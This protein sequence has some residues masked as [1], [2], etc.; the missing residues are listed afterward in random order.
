MFHKLMRLIL[1]V[2]LLLLLWLKATTITLVASTKG[3]A[4]Q[5]IEKERNALLDFRSYIDQ[6][7]YD[8]LFTWAVDEETTR[9]C[10]KWGGVTCNSRTRHVTSFDS[11][12]GDLE[13]KI[14]PSLL[15]LSY[16]SH[17]DLHWNS[18]N[19]TISILNGSMT[20]LRYLDLSTNSLSGDIPMFI[21]SMTRLRYL[22]LSTN[23][24]N[25]SIPMFIGSMTRLRYLDLSYN[26]F[27]GLGYPFPCSLV[28]IVED[29]MQNV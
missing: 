5:C 25:G 29:P 15:N 8:L 7:P 14:S 28:L 18:F 10:C 19:G 21:G 13:G 16:L 17:L 26:S 3:A 12:S 23:F 9:D 4:P 11:S 2:L 1:F 22:D 27:S 20:K 24:F 6:D